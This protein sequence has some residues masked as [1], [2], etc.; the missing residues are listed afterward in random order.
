MT[1]IHSFGLLFSC[2]KC[3]IRRI[4][5]ELP[6]LV[7]DVAIRYHTFHAGSNQ[8]LLVLL[9]QVTRCICRFFA[10]PEMSR[11]LLLYFPISYNWIECIY[12]RVSMAEKTKPLSPILSLVIGR[13]YLKTPHCCVFLMLKCSH[14]FSWSLCFLPHMRHR[15]SIQCQSR[16]YIGM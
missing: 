6:G 12:Y 15:G 11:H 10:L 9:G 7:M 5:S 8:C 4:C 14:I 2:Q 13:T 3:N 1:N 16:E